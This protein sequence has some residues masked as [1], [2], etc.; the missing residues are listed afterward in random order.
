M[1]DYKVEPGAIVYPNCQIGTGSIIGANAVLRP[2]TR[3]GHDSIFGT[4]SCSEG[5]NDIGSYTTIHAQCHITQGVHIGDNVF[6]APYFIAS[7]TP[8]ITKGAHGI[9]GPKKIR[10]KHTYIENNVRMGCSVRMIPGLRIGHDSLIEQDT[11]ITHD[12]EP[13]SIVRGGKDKVGRVV[14]RTN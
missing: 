11:F 14:G 2:Y 6:I 3:I 7:N 4:L 10:I 9:E 8:D 5:H 1:V 12:I 13:Y